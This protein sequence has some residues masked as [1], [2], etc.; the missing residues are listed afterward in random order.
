M[1][2]LLDEVR[3]VAGVVPRIVQ[4]MAATGELEEH[5]PALRHIYEAAE[6]PRPEVLGG[7]L[8][9]LTLRCAEPYCFVVYGARLCALDVRLDPCA[10]GQ[11]YLFPAIVPDHQRWSRVLGLLVLLD[12]EGPHRRT[13]E[14][15]LR[16]YTSAAQFD[17]L[18]HLVTAAHLLM[19]YS[20]R[21]PIDVAEERDLDAL[22]GSVRARIPELVRFHAE[23]NGRPRPLPALCS[24]CRKVQTCA[25]E[26][27]LP[28]ELAAER[29][30]QGVAYRHGLCPGCEVVL[31]A[32]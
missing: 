28:L 27:W 5:W 16:S 26:G 15:A 23:F 32:S 18:R 14:H 25:D 1:T 17:S 19:S 21:H 10:L 9:T 31:L 7:L 3:R 4:H 2:E 29:L 6:I 11:R 13:A 30:P 12:I 8:A 20:A 24:G 22:P